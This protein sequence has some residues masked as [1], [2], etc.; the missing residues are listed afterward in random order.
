[1]RGIKG[2]RFAGVLMLIAFT[3]LA[4][5]WY[6]TVT[7]ERERYLT[8]RNFRL[9][10]TVATQL[11]SSISGQHRTLATLLT[12]DPGKA[13][14]TDWFRKARSFV[15]ALQALDEDR[16]PEPLDPVPPGS[17]S[18]EV[19]KSEAVVDDRGAWLVLTMGRE[20]EGSLS[21]ASTRPVRLTLD[22][23][24]APIFTP[25]LRER[26][27]DALVLASTEGR[28]LHAE[29]QLSGV[30]ALARLDQLE[31][32]S[33]RLLTFGNVA[34]PSRPPGFAS[35]ARTSGVVDVMISGTAYKLFTQPCCLATTTASADG[36]QKPAGLV[37]VGLVDAA[38]F[39][40]KARMASTPRPFLNWPSAS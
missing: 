6:L 31:P 7:A 28:V 18:R 40:S 33:R 36:P 15:P 16:I 20:A 4:A 25:K 22:G 11:D 39:R 13:K 5:T 14:A 30:L 21:P 37:I 32:A 24:L 35:V 17:T 19:R 1:M 10:S 23:V 38:A 12:T 2:L 26:A 34:Q 27:F 8:S 3:A 29:G 9:L